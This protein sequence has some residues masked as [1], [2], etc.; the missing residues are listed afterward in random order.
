M[1]FIFGLAAVVA[2]LAALAWALADGVPLETYERERIERE[3]RRNEL[4]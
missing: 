4:G 2:V 1:I 3:R